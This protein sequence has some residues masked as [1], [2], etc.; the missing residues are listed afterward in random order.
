MSVSAITTTTTTAIAPIISIN[1]YPYPHF[2]SPY[3]PRTLLPPS[4]SSI[5][6]NEMDRHCPTFS[7]LCVQFPEFEEWLKTDPPCPDQDADQDS[8]QDSDHIF[9][10]LRRGQPLSSQDIFDANLE[11]WAYTILQEDFIDI[12]CREIPQQ[13]QQK[14]RHVQWLDSVIESVHEAWSHIEYDRKKVPDY[15]RNFCDHRDEEDEEIQKMDGIGLSSEYVSGLSSDQQQGI[16]IGIAI[17]IRQNILP[18]YKFQGSSG[19][20]DEEDSQTI[21]I[22]PM[23]RN[24]SCNFSFMGMQ[25]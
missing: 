14:S 22:A 24:K 11:H 19:F 12:P 4:S 9:Q 8:D 17:P 13:K 20:S 16:G 6:V 2:V 5:L 18:V 25:M 21:S 23:R 3:S 7:E 10:P 15:I 1:T